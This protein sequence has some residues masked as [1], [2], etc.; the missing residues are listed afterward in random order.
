MDKFKKPELNT[1]LNPV[2]YFNFFGSFTGIFDGV[3]EAIVKSETEIC[4]VL[5]GAINEG[6]IDIPT[7][8][9]VEGLVHTHRKNKLKIDVGSKI[10]KFMLLTAVKFKGDYSA[11]ISF[12]TFY[13]MKSEVPYIRVGT[14]YF[15]MIKKHDRYNNENFILKPWNKDEIKL[16]HG[17]QILSLIYKF[18]DF[19]IVPS[20]LDY[21]P[22]LN[23]C[24]NLY[25][26]FVHVPY[27]KPVTMD[28][29][30]A[31]M[32]VMNQI[33][34]EQL[35]LGFKYMK[36]LYER[37]WQI[38]PVLSLVSFKRGTGKTTY[39][40]WI[41]MLFGENCTLI[42]PAD[43]TISF[44]DSY[45]TKN[46]IMIDETVIDKAHTIEKLK[47]IATA[48]T[49]SVSQ[50]FVNHY[51][52]PFY[53]KIIMCT[54]K[55]TDFMRIDEEEVRFW[56][57]KL[58]PLESKL[59]TN[60]E[61]KLF[62]EIPMFLRYISDLPEI[63]YSRSRMVFTE[64]EIK[65]ASLFNIKEESKSTLRKEIEY[66]VTDVFD[67]YPGMEYFEMTPKD[68]KDKW[69]LRNQNVSISYI[70]KV[71]KEEMKVPYSGEVK[72]YR[73]LPGEDLLNQKLGR[74]YKFVNKNVD[75]TAASDDQPF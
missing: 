13:V 11:A 1:L 38:L 23:N 69:F 19:T 35:D 26:K 2:D 3:K 34:G 27:S 18:D 72:R 44:N 45:A 33:F 17:K 20:N 15:K 50:K 55:E 43:L 10:S 63:D 65:T 52:V 9:L 54:N 6:D 49:M 4:G 40:N 25:C 62:N 75:P 60:I 31:T 56:V 74:V 29:M 68:I 73:G 53:G 58:E 39:L 46:I 41:Q 67:N 22:V 7:F 16:D 57:R 70:R 30:P 64:D 21:Q 37:P 14:N 61:E 47:S 12:V 66:F 5:E 48:K 59:D 42:N 51:S 28:M 32:G 71:L 24:Y 8:T 36:V